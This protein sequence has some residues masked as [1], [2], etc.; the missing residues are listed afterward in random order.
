L[1]T[2]RRP[3]RLSALAMTLA[4]EDMQSDCV[5]I[6]LLG[7]GRTT[8]DGKKKRVE[9]ERCRCVNWVTQS[10]AS[11]SWGPPQ[12]WDMYRNGTFRHPG[13]LGRGVFCDH[14]HSFLL[15][16]LVPWNH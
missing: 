6:P 16:A 12:A 13:W 15:Q 9:E 3:L 1:L 10:L 4:L 11:P 8:Y 2:L 14:R 7:K 5:L